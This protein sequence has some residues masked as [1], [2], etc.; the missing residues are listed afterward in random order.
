M[1]REIEARFTKDEI[2]ELYLNHIY[3]GN[4]VRGLRAGR[5]ALLPPA[6]EHPHPAPGRRCFRRPAQGAHPY[7]RPAPRGRPGAARPGAAPDGGAGSRS[8]AAAAA[9]A[10]TPLGVEPPPRQAR[11]APGLA[12]TSWRPSAG[13]LEERFGEEIYRRPLRVWTTLDSAAQRLA[14]QELERQLAADRGGGARPL[15]SAPLLAGERA[16]G[17]R[18]A[19]PSRALVLL[20]AADGDVLAW[21]GGR[22]FRQSQ[23]DRVARAPRRQAGSAWKPFVYAAALA[24][25]WACSQPLSDRPF[26]LRLSSGRVWQPRNFGARYDVQVTLRDALVRSKNVATVQL[27]REIGADGIV[28]LAARA[29]IASPI[30]RHPSMPLGTAALSPLE[31]TAAYTAFAGL[32]QGVRPRLVRG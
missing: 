18:D 4:G 26:A 10:E 16:G 12:P 19:L 1:A 25:G 9:A 27:A 8:P 14:E 29:G 3:L 28:D 22:D 30:P 31:L 23:F 13:E 21:V 15:P 5:R 6:G 24:E 17:G 2:L 32:G 11:S 7:R 20:Q